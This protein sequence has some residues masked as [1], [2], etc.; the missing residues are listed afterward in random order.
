MAVIKSCTQA[1]ERH[2]CTVMGYTL[3]E[4]FRSKFRPRSNATQNAALKPVDTSP[5]IK[6]IEP[7]L[8]W[9]AVAYAAGFL[10]VMLHI[11]QARHTSHAVDRAYLYSGG[12]TACL[13]LVL[14]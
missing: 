9:A 10:T 13:D 14:C 11:A 5:K 12:H 4:M 2:R 1:I 8:K 3:Q 6:D 7:I